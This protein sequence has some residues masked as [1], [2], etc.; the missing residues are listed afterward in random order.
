MSSRAD[1]AVEEIFSLFDK[2][3][4]ENYIGEE[5]SQLQHAQQAAACAMKEGF[6]DFVILGAFLHDIGCYRTEHLSCKIFILQV[7]W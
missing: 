7:I 3:G 5:V 6:D 1:R 4:G 2:F